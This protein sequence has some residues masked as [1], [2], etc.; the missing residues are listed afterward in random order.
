MLP[1]VDY[2]APDSAITLTDSLADTGFAVLTDHGIPVDQLRSFFSDW[3]NYFTRGDKPDFSADPVTQAGYFSTADAETAL[4]AHHQDLKE[5]FQYWPGTPLPTALKTIT[6]SLHQQMLALASSVLE[7]LQKNTPEN[8]WARL[9]QPLRDCLSSQDTMIRILRYPP[10]TGEEPAG[11]IRAGAHQD[12]N[13]ITLLPAA[14][15]PGLEIKP[16]GGDWQAVDVPDGAIIVN[17]GDMLQELTNGSLPSTTHRVVNPETAL[18]TARL[19]AP[20]F[21]HPDPGLVLSDRYTAGSYLNERLNEINTAQM[22][23]A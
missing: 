20:L 14:S 16:R 9:K 15:E 18:S 5:Y 12:I 2:S 19:T 6:E 7:H 13:F 3:D 17:I 23:P 21:C 22:R 4:N 10:V 11:A 8:L 1:L